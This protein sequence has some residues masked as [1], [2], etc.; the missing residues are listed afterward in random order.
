[1]RGEIK[2][3]QRALKS[4]LQMAMHLMLCLCF[5]LSSLSSS[6]ARFISPDD[7]DPTLPGV[8]TN[9]YAYSDNDPVNKSDP[10]GHFVDPMGNWYPGTNE[11]PGYAYNPLANPGTTALMMATPIGAAIAGS[12]AGIV[13]FG[14]LELNSIANDDISSAGWGGKIFGKAQVTKDAWHAAKSA[15]IAKAAAKDPSVKEVYLNSKYNTAL[16]SKNVSNKQPDVIVKYHNKTCDAY[17]C[18]SASQT[19]KS[20]A[21]KLARERKKINVGGADYVIP[22]PNTSNGSSSLGGSQGYNGAS[23]NPSGG[24]PAGGSGGSGFWSAF[25]SFFGF[26]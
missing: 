26:K 24:G 11:D 14:A 19:Q 13:L 3:G 22:N 21:D 8:G 25:K 4:G 10:N 17:E 12:T 5:I 16:G 2:M 23:G 9:R 7:W 20:Q 1:M 6:N 15:E 18:V